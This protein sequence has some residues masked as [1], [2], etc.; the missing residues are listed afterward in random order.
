M[1]HHNIRNSWAWTGGHAD[2]DKDLLHVAIKEAMEET[3]LI[4]VTPLMEKIAS[5][6][7]LPVFGHMRKGKYVS[8]HLHLSIAYIL[9]AS[10]EDKLVIKEDENSGVCWFNIE[11]FTKKY[12]DEHDLYLYGKL[13]RRAKQVG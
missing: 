6:D 12:F 2:G 8:A 7:I 10:D 3:G 5:I 1:V 13:I 4:C 11:K 9:I